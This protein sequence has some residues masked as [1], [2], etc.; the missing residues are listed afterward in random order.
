[1]IEA[2]RKEHRVDVLTWEPPN[3]EKIDRFFGTALS[4]NELQLILIPS[5]YKRLLSLSLTPTALLRGNMLLRYGRTL[6]R[7]YDLLVTANNES[8]LGGRGVQ[9]VYYPKL[10]RERPPLDFRWYHRLPLILSGYYWFCAKATG[11]SLGRMKSNVTLATSNW[12]GD[13]MRKLHGIDSLTVYPPV[14]GEFRNVP[15]EKRQNG[16]VCIGRISPEKRIELMIEILA[17]VR[18]RC[19][20]IRL[21]IIGTADD[22]A[23]TSRIRQEVRRNADWI[24]LHE[25]LSRAALVDLVSSNRYGIHGMRDEHFGMGVA[26]MLRAGCV[27]FVPDSGGQVEIVGGDERF[28]Y[29]DAEEASAKIIQTLTDAQRQQS[30][31]SY[32]ER[33]KHLFSAE[34][35]AERIRAIVRDRAGA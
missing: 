10:D 1:M 23:Y 6:R 16:F 33:R 28:L 3:L 13:R 18:R 21:H 34:L 32:L 35:F 12:I 31:R 4:R 17:R 5:L 22:R 25:D 14:A 30:M 24:F 19:S 20:E 26:E 7:D 15:W 11:F 2:L 8:D 29:R 9:Y 27:V